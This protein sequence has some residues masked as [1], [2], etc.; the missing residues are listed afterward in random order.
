MVELL[1]LLKGHINFEKGMDETM[2]P[3]YLKSAESYVYTATGG[4]DQYSILLVAGIMNEYRAADKELESALN[5]ITPFIVQA[6]FNE[7]AE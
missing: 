2:L 3:V 1:E 4:S 6:V 7:V 5:A